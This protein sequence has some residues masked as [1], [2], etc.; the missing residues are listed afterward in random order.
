M[1]YTETAISWSNGPG[2]TYSDHRHDYDKVL[3]VE[4]GSISFTLPDG[5]VLL[6][7]GDRLELPAGTAH[8]ALV[9]PDGVRC[10]E[11]HL[12]RGS[13]APLPRPETTSGQET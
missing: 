9:G 11:T 6:R 3:T 7:S 10:L 12:P 5:S 2:E 13:V 8:G 1:S 4:A